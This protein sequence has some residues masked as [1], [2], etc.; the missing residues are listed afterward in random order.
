[1]PRL[2]RPALALL[3]GVLLAAAPAHASS[4]PDCPDPDALPAARIAPASL[5]EGQHF[6]VEPCARLVGHLARFRLHPR[7]PPGADALDPPLLEVEGLDLLA[8]RVAE[9]EVLQELR[10]IGRAEAAGAAA[11]SALEDT[12]SALGAVVG[13]PVESVIGLPAGA[14]RLVGRRAG[15]LGRQAAEVG[16]RAVE[17]MAAPAVGSELRLRPGIEPETGP[18]SEPWWRAGGSLALRLGQR[19][20]GYAAARRDLAQRLGIDP[21]SGNPWLDA[22]MDRLAWAALAGRRGLGAGL[23]QLGPAAG[24]AL[25]TGHRVHRL[26]WTRPPE[27]ITAWNRQRLAVLRCG[28]TARDR[29]LDNARFS[30]PLQTAV[31][32]A[33]LA[34][35]PQQGCDLL[36][37]SATAV[38]REVDARYLVD[39][40]HLLVAA[41][42]RFPLRFEAVGQ[43][44]VMRDG[45]ERL[46][47]ALPVDRLAWTP[48]TADHF[49]APGFAA[50]ADRHLLV[51]RSASPEARAALLAQ[52]WSILEEAI[53]P[54]RMQA[55]APAL[56]PP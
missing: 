9:M 47:L 31:V 30:P 5:L 2:P 41:Q 26:V 38:E 49:A 18:E 35:A 19:W 7:L 45:E 46:W 42:A 50:V 29:F 55:P 52:G 25:S 4:L 51:G 27:A 53:G 11:W 21:Y 32:D 56:P 34:L 16:E 23:G 54:A 48:D 28:T 20:L 14:L 39:L 40:L 22:E 33:L 15:E 24:A 44:L 8:Q 17:A 37:D 6:V 43:A 10:A 36:L 13:R 3:A 12:G 1:M